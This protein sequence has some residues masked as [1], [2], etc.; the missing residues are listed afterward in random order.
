MTIAQPIG[1]QLVILEPNGRL[2]AE[3]VGEFSQAVAKCLRHGRCEMIL[4]LS[5]VTYLDSAG[6][7]SLVQAYKCSQAYGGRLVFA[8]VAGKSRELL[9]VTKLL[10]IFEVYDTKADAEG[11]FERITV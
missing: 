11:S 3:T 10:T 6:I 2:T 9:R 8:H 7:G 4:D 5:Y 1:D